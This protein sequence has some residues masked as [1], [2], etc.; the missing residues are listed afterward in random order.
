MKKN[1]LFVM[2]A[3]LLLMGQMAWALDSWPKGWGNG[4][5]ACALTEDGLFTVP[6]PATNDAMA[7]FTN[8]MGNMTA[9]GNWTDEGNYS[10]SFSHIDGSTYYIDSEADLALIA[11]KVNTGESDF[12]GIT[13]SLSKELDMAAHYWVPIGT[14]DHPF[15]GNF[16]GNGHVIRN[17]TV[18]RGSDAY[19]GLFGYVQGTLR[20][21]NA[22]GE[23]GCDYIKNV[24]VKAS[25]ISGGDYTG[26]IVGN[27]HGLATLENAICEANVSGTNHVGGIIGYVDGHYEQV[28]TNYVESIATV[29]DCLFAWGTVTGTGNRAA[30]IGTIGKWVDR[31]NNYYI[32]E[33]SATGNSYDVRAYPI[34]HSIP[35]NL[36]FSIYSTPGRHYNGVYYAPNSTAH[37]SLFYNDLSQTI[38]SVQVNNVELGTSSGHYSFAIDGNSAVTY[39]ITVTATDSGTTGSG[40]SEND[41]M[42]IST[43]EQWNTFANDVS[44]GNSFIGKFLRLGDNITVSTMAGSATGYKPFQGTFDGNNFTLTFNRGTSSVPFDEDHCAPFRY[45]FNATIKNLKVD[46]EIY[47]SNQYAAG[48]VGYASADNAVGNTIS[49]CISSITI[50]STK[51]GEGRHG[52][53]IGSVWCY[54]RTS[55]QNCVFDGKLLGPDTNGVGGFVGYASRS[56]TGYYVTINDS[57]FVPSEVTVSGTYSNCFVTSIGNMHGHVNSSYYS[58]VLGEASDGESGTVYPCF[59]TIDLDSNKLYRKHSLLNG[60]TYYSEVTISGTSD[61]YYADGHV[62]DINP[63]LTYGN[64]VALVSGIDYYLYLMD[65]EGQIDELTQRGHYWLFIMGANENYEGYVILEF[66]VISLPG[67][68]ALDPTQNGTE[69]YPFFIETADDWNTFVTIV[70]HGSSFE[71]KFIELID[72]ITVTT[73]VGTSDHKFSGTFDGGYSMHS[74]TFNSGTSESHFDEEYCAPFRYIDGATIKRLV[75]DGSIHTDRKFAAGVVA[76][77]NGNWHIRDCLSKITINS[78]VEGDGTHGGFVAHVVSCVDEG[79]SEFDQCVF[80][81]QLLGAST[82]NIGGFAGAVAPGCTLRMMDCLFLPSAP[83]TMGTTGSQAFARYA[84]EPVFD[85]CYYSYTTDWVTN[86]GVRAIVYDYEPVGLGFETAP[87][88][89]LRCFDHGILFDSKYYTDLAPN[90]FTSENYTSWYETENWSKGELPTANDNVIIDGTATI[91]H[92][93]GNEVVYPAATAGHIVVNEGKSLTIMDGGQ[94]IHGNEGVVATVRKTINP[95]EDWATSSKGWYFVASPINYGLAPSSADMFGNIDFDLYRLNNTVWENYRQHYDNDGFS[96]VNGKGY[97]YANK[98]YTVLSFSGLIKAYSEEATDNQVEVSEG[99]NLIGNPFVCNVYPNRAFYKMNAE[100]SAIEAVE[101]ADIASNPVAPCTGIVVYAEQDGSVTFFKDAPVSSNGN[102]GNIQIALAQ[103]SSNRG[104]SKIDN[105]IVSFN[106]GS[107][108]PKFRFGGNAEIYIP[109]GNED[110]AIVSVGRDGVHTVSTEM[111]INFKANENGTYTITVNPENVELP[112][113]HLIDNMTGADVDLLATKGGD[114]INRINGGDAK[115]CVSTYTF[116]AKTTDYESRFRLVFVANSE[117]GS[118]TGSEAFAFI[119]NGNIIVNG[120]GTLQVVDVMGRVIVCRDGVHT[121]STAGMP[122][123]VY[124]L[125][126]VNGKGVQTQKIVVE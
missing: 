47:T 5:T 81:G 56:D 74:I 19:N 120:E 58:Q 119:S 78:Y 98:Q 99:W 57:F 96:L 10:A 79:Y 60:Q 8:N 25:T 53:F 85:R 12:Y 59:A 105:A 100:G 6:K 71:G 90:V 37:F 77:A 16:N 76:N 122:A 67:S 88:Y 30:V 31:S 62:I 61:T 15:K 97:L 126:L 18:N 36:N 106:E 26:G 4:N 118:S 117:D 102:N 9:S 110:Y 70:E 38:T 84:L 45:I 114:A 1:K 111:P 109:Q 17:I 28:G 35:T 41:P 113:L 64:N 65:A 50:H 103:A 86:Q 92:D 87:N 44:N 80:N 29:K 14:P 49:N 63:R 108:L 21:Y 94:L 52:G 20:H 116:T 24:V 91:P 11:H 66:D 2:L 54:G 46:G 95:A 121:V 93:D 112:Y 32:N 123:G 55:F 69:T 22:Y 13:F 51:V 39:N 82:D 107:L 3:L 42:V 27:L 34:T 124:V 104:A 72:D 40:D 43:A 33:T 101:A 23:G 48:L 75:V 89:Y 125:R 68:N 73:M 83:V 7:D 115:H